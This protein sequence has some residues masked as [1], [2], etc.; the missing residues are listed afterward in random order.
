MR[1]V[2]KPMYYRASQIT[3][4]KARKLRL[5][6][7]VAESKLWELLKVNNSMGLNLGDNIRSKHLSSIFTVIKLS[8]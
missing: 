8:W 2:E 6:E 7:T 5:R 1:E 4:E 3:F